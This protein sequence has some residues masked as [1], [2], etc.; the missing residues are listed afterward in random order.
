MC[1]RRGCGMC[2][3]GG[4]LWDVGSLPRGL[5]FLK[6]PSEAN[7]NQAANNFIL[8]K[9][10]GPRSIKGVGLLFC[11][12]I[13]S[14]SAALWPCPTWHCHGGM[15]EFPSQLF[16]DS[17][18]AL[19]SSSFSRSTSSVS[20]SRSSTARRLAKWSAWATLPPTTASCRKPEMGQRAA[21]RP[22]VHAPE[23]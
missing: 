5:F 7:L 22:R 8:K 15:P 18:S 11:S 1:C 14:P 21:E 3:V 2:Y 12:T 4:G 10:T 9:R 6:K 17:A 13:K 20:W 23:L 16:S 19:T